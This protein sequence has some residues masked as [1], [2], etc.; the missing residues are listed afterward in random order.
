LAVVDSM[1]YRIKL[2]GPQGSVVGLLQRQLVPEPVTVAIRDAE[3]ARRREAFSTPGAI[4]VDGVED[5]EFA[6]RLRATLLEQVENMVFAEVIPVIADMAVGPGDLIWVA[7][8]G[9][10][11]D[12]HGP[13]DILTADGAYIGTLPTGGP[14]IPDA[15]GPDGLMAYI[16]TDDLDVPVVRVI[17]LVG[18]AVPGEQEGM[19]DSLLYRGGEG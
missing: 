3:R 19:W 18:V 2:I 14:E 7:R 5:R 6:E 17:R 8:T 15:F 9:P 1:A 13:I 16:E 11:G 12:G 4:H 10:G